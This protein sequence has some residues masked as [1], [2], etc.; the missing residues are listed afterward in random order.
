MQGPYGRVSCR[1]PGT[2][3]SPMPDAVHPAL[4]EFRVE[5]FSIGDPRMAPRDHAPLHAPSTTGM[6]LPPRLSMYM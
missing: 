3:C 4:E 6:T 2:C 1:S 5:K